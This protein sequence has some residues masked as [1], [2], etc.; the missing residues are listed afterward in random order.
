MCR[1]LNVRAKKTERRADNKLCAC[2]WAA[3][4]FEI[5]YKTQYLTDG[6]KFI[7]H[8]IINMDYFH[9]EQNTA[10][11]P[12]INQ[13]HSIFRGGSSSRAPNVVSNM[14]SVRTFK[15]WIW[16]WTLDMEFNRVY[17]RGVAGGWWP[18]LHSYL[19]EDETVWKKLCRRYFQTHFLEW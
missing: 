4:K 5:W 15:D 3:P 8:P 6:L 7:T 17:V 13:T 18:I 11:V 12:H 10:H 9:F 19:V 14:K 2:I 16:F 1:F